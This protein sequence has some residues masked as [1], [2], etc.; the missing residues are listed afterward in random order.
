MNQY[1]EF[2]KEWTEKY[3]SMSDEELIASFN[4]KVGLRTFGMFISILLSTLENE[5]LSRNWDL[6]GVIATDTE[7]KRN[8]TISYALPIQLVENKLVVIKNYFWFEKEK[9]YLN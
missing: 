1:L 9:V 3:K 2:R 6:S 5:M 4:D 7:T 8:I